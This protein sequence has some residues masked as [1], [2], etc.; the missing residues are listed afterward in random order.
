MLWLALACTPNRAPLASFE[1]ARV[2]DRMVWTYTRHRE[3]F[4]RGWK[5][6]QVL[7]ADILLELEVV[8]LEPERVW[9]RLRANDAEGVR[10]RHPALAQD[11]LIPVERVPAKERVLGPIDGR[12]DAPGGTFRYTTA[13]QDQRPQGGWL[14]TEGWARAE[15]PLYMSDG[16]LLLERTSASENKILDEQRLEIQGIAPG[17]SGEG[18]LPEGLTLL[19]PGSWHV[20]GR[21][22]QDGLVATRSEQRLQGATLVQT[23]ATYRPAD[24]GSASSTDCIQVD[25]D[26]VCRDALPQSVTLTLLPEVLMDLATRATEA[27]AEGGLRT[28][29]PTLSGPVEVRVLSLPDSSYLDGQ[30]VAG[31]QSLAFATHPT[32][33][34]GLFFPRALDPLE[35]THR[36]PQAARALDTRAALWAW[37]EKEP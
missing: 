6:L 18:E 15:G 5:E 25:T 7:D 2:G 3:D 9:L 21:W 33:L 31:E 16:L 12:I 10:L 26:V 11:L 36:F 14:R 1:D 28:Q 27:P 32:A 34:P 8:A 23:R 4:R 19:V 20:E 29:H 30:E 22:T 17:R 13:R 35:E 37:S 24:K